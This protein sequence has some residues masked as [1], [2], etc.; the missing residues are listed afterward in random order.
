M[1]RSVICALLFVGVV[2]V[3][4]AALGGGGGPQCEKKTNL[5]D[6]T[7]WTLIP[8]DEDPFAAGKDGLL[9]RDESGRFPTDYPH[10]RRVCGDVDVFA[11][12]LDGDASLT[13]DTNTCGWATSQ[14]TLA[15]A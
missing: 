13:T 10:D 12:E 6:N 3:I 15:E 5:I 14:E 7:A 9:E 11:E 2:T 8:I 1:K 4:A